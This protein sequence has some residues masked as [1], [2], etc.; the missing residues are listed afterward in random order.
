MGV[1]K[2][3]D[4]LLPAAVQTNAGQQQPGEPGDE[5]IAPADPGDEKSNWK[6]AFPPTYENKQALTY[7]SPGAMPGLEKE[8]RVASQ[9]EKAKKKN[10]E[11]VKKQSWI[12]R[13]SRVIS[14]F[15]T[16][17]SLIL[18]EEI[19][20]DPS[21]EN[22]VQAPEQRPGRRE[23]EDIIRPARMRCLS[24]R[25]G[26]LAESSGVPHNSEFQE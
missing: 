17:K 3:G 5:G 24:V 20:E 14:S 2:E 16:R 12:S 13:G 23:D 15:F 19:K 10:A 26:A 7:Y 8:M 18:E 11:P 1:K 21:K 4:V 25:L 22:E 6:A 9:L